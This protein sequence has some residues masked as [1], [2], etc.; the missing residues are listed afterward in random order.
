MERTD[1]T[2]GTDGADGGTERDVLAALACAAG[3]ELSVEVL[4]ALVNVVRSRERPYGEED[5]TALVRAAGTALE[6]HEW[7]GRPEFLLV[8]ARPAPGRTDPEQE[9]AIT[10]ALLALVPADDSGRRRWQGAAPYLRDHLAT[11]AAAAGRLEELVHTAGFLTFADPTT[12]ARVLHRVDRSRSP[13]L[14]AYWRALDRLRAAAPADRPAVLQAMAQCEEPEAFA[15]LD[16]QDTRDLAEQAGWTPAWA[17]EDGRSAFHRRLPGHSEHPTQAQVQVHAL[18][19]GTAADGPVLASGGRNGTVRLWDPRTGELLSTLAGHTGAALAMLEFG[20]VDGR[21]VLAS[22]AEDGTVRVWDLG[23]GES[24][25]GFSVPAGYARAAAFVTLGD[26]RNVLA[27]ASGFEADETDDSDTGYADDAGSVDLWDPLTGDHVARLFEHY[28]AMLG[29]AAVT[30]AGRAAVAAVDHGVVRVWDVG[31]QRPIA[32]WS[33]QHES[34]RL[35]PFVAPLAA[36]TWDGRE[37]L[38]LVAE[39]DGTGWDYREWQQTVLLWDP[40]A[41]P[42]GKLIKRFDLEESESVLAIGR[43]GGGGITTVLATAAPRSYGAGPKDIGVWVRELGPKIV[44]TLHAHTCPFLT[45]AFGTVDG[46][47]LL[48]TANTGHRDQTEQ[49]DH[50]ITLMDVPSE[51]WSSG[52]PRAGGLTLGTDGQRQPVLMVGGDYQAELIDPV[53]GRSTGRTAIVHCDNYKHG[54]SRGVAV[55]SGTVDGSPLLAVAGIGHGVSLCDPATGSVVRELREYPNGWSRFVALGDTG[56]RV[57]LPGRR[58]VDAKRVYLLAEADTSGPVTVWDAAT[59]E[60]LTTMDARGR[61]SALTFGT[62]AGRTVLATG[63]SGVIHLWDPVKGKH[64]EHFPGGDAGLAFGSLAGRDVFATAL[65]REVRIG[66]ATDGRLLSV[67]E[68]PWATVT[69]LALAPVDG[70]P[71]LVTGDDSGTVRMWDPA[72]GRYLTTL[73]TFARVVHEVVLETIGDEAYVFAQSRSGRLTACRL[74]RAG[75]REAPV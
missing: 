73:A 11:H 6:E 24:P 56:R 31:T 57:L 39:Q 51:Y 21:P 68:N 69:C 1:L 19:F 25:A 2:D 44:A 5:L 37:V 15:T 23:T 48:A 40:A 66:D 13:L 65:G 75:R 14:R 16:G 30:V 10:D 42:A 59:G 20:T 49:D 22:G 7:N 32:Q 43:L 38:V 70:R 9:S 63:H 3:D 27:V 74:S 72:T 47:T 18:A 28:S 12:L 34:F 67:V 45:G 62:V 52:T 53:T 4:L 60:I 61:L 46:R 33:D 41:G 35:P 55:A 29:L 64:L 26:G 58:A 54:E 71:L 17:G 36:A 8:A 50:A